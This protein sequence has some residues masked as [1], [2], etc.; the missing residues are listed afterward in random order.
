[1]TQSK[2][3]DSS[4]FSNNR[5]KLVAKFPKAP[6]IITANGL[7]QKTRDDDAFPFKQSANFW[8][9][10]GLNEPDVILL[11]HKGHEYL[12]LPKKDKHHEIFTGGFNIDEIKNTTGIHNILDSHEGWQLLS[13]LVKKSKQIGAITAGPEYVKIYNVYTNPATR[14]L[15]RRLKALN[16]NL[17]LIDLQPH[18]SSLRVIKTTSEIDMIQHCVDH[19]GKLLAE[20]S[21]NFKNYKNEQEI[22]AEVIYY[23]AKNGFEQAFHPIIANGINACTLHYH[24]N[25]A[26]ITTNCRHCL[27]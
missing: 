12:I 5:Q 14:R 22:E 23:A 26:V 27:I 7:L 13:P 24:A 16:K 10:T 19:T 15:N 2:A 17:I 11:I 6:I 1:M 4:F 8:Y 21:R 25:N 18:I 9:L 3:L 20:I